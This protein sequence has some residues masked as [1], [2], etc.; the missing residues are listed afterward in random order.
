M[1]KFY[2]EIVPERVRKVLGKD[3]TLQQIQFEDPAAKLREELASA[4]PGSSRYL[5][6]TDKIG[7]LEREAERYGAVGNQLGF[8]ITPEIRE[9]F[10]KPIPYKKGGSVRISDNPDTMRLELLRK[11]HA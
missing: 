7:Q 10:S 9:K 3:S 5:Y 4:T 2:D 1:K 11:K 8:D 6:L